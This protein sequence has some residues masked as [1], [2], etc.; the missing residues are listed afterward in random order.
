MKLSDHYLLTIALNF[1]YNRECK[2]PKVKNPYSTKV[3]EYNLFEA[4]E[5]DWT[6]FSTVLEGISRNF[7]E[8]TKNENVETKLAKDMKILKEQLAW[9]SKRKLT[10]KTKLL[11]MMQRRSQRTKFQKGFGL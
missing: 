10:L 4:S 1:S 3:Y 2:V 9:F 5:S 7:E 6:R 8:E 11:M